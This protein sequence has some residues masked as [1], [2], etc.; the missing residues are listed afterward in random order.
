[1]T[2]GLVS[3]WTDIGRRIAV[4]AGMGVALIALISDCP[5][6]VACARGAATI[7]ALLVLAHVVARLLV[8][9]HAG[10]RQ[11]RLAASKEARSQMN[12]TGAPR[13]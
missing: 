12:S 13:V 4:I 8:W 3:A 1:M 6:W 7:A 10:D 9:S 5:L 11:E 2:T